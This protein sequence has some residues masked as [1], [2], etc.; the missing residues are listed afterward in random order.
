MRLL[1]IAA[2]LVLFGCAPALA[3]VCPVVITAPC[4]ITTDG[5]HILGANID[6]TNAPTQ[7]GTGYQA[8]I[9]I[10]P[11]V[12]YATINCDIFSITHNGGYNS[13]GVGIYGTRVAGVEIWGCNIYGQGMLFGIDIENDA[14]PDYD[15]ITVRDSVISARLVGIVV[16]SHT[17]RITDNLLRYMGRQSLWSDNFP[18]GITVYGLGVG[19]ATITG[20][21]VYQL[22]NP[23]GSEVFGISCTEC[24]TGVIA[25]NSVENTNKLANSW[26]YWVNP[27]KYVITNNAAKNFDKGFGLVT[28]SKGSISGSA[29]D[30]V[31]T[32]YTPTP[33]APGWTIDS[34]MGLGLLAMPLAQQD[35]PRAASRRRPARKQPSTLTQMLKAIWGPG[36]K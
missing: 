9:V 21:R 29:F 27:G 10:A 11:S 14:N 31:T 12:T 8:A 7:P 24:F 19:N 32:P 15:T 33:P 16:R 4:T 6:A 18:G 5:D 26:A 25:N 22:E 2:A 23:F 35:P 20:N 28:N 34:G 13:R 17:V 3:A 36:P 1:L 30:N